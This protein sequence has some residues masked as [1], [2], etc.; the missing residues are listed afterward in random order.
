MSYLPEAPESF[1]VS[2]EEARGQVE[3]DI[4]CGK[5][6]ARCIWC[7]N[8]FI[9][10]YYTTRQT[11]ELLSMSQQLLSMSQKLLSMP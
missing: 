3:N 8:R 9:I 1:F 2:A 7:S 5:V 11:L 6:T 10:Q 4:E